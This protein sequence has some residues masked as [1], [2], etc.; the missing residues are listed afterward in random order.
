MFAE[1]VEL[2][3]NNMFTRMLE[4][5]Y[6]QPEEFEHMASDLFAAMS[7][8]GRVG[9]EKVAWFNGGLFRR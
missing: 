9:F 8:G 5:A 4:Q 2:L 6:E 3:P 1:D 7:T